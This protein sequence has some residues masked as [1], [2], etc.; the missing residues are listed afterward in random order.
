MSPLPWLQKFRT[1][2]I[3]TRRLVIRPL[4]RGDDRAILPAVVESMP[5]LAA[6]LPWAT[7]AYNASACRA[8]VRGA[9]RDYAAGRDFPLAIF[10]RDGHLVGG[11]GFHLR[12]PRDAPYFE[13]GYWCRSA[14]AGNGYITEATGALLRHAFRAREVY[15][16]E[17][18]AIRATAPAR[19]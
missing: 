19:A 16:V 10:T 17:I 13:I 14:L 15:R 12:G 18:G 9:M 2:P 3:K 5:E 4:R 8:F 1:A 6:W 7:P 11:T